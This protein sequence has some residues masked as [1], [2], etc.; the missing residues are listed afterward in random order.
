MILFATVLHENATL[1][2]QAKT[3]KQLNKKRHQYGGGLDVAK[4]LLVSGSGSAVFLLTSHRR[5]Y[6]CGA[7]SQGPSRPLRRVPARCNF[8]MYLATLTREDL[9]VH[10]NA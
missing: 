1:R 2:R 10:A 4:I 8:Y 5:D 3:V 9:L 6:G 7:A